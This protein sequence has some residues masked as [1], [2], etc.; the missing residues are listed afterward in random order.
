MKF[1]L[2]EIAYSV[3]LGLLLGLI[4]AHIT[5]YVAAIAISEELTTQ[6]NPEITV[7]IIGV[8]TQFL[9]FGILAIFVGMILGRLPARW[10]LTSSFCYLGFIL[11]LSVGSAFVYDTDI[12]N[13]YSGITQWPLAPSFIVLPMCLFIATYCSAK[14]KEQRA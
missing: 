12:F 4:G 7:L 5:G 1:Q 14:R 9:G 13:P 3:L 8:I 11:Y 2:K 6:L 10:L